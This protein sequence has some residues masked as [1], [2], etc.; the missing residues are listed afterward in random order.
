MKK[1]KVINE[2]KKE[3]KKK[4]MKVEPFSMLPKFVS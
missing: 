4:K 3:R 2:I 1:K